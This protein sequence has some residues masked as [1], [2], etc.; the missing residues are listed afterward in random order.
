MR[1]RPAPH[2]LG[3]GKL[4]E[5]ERARHYVKFLVFAVGIPL[6]LHAAKW[7]AQAP[8][9]FASGIQIQQVIALPH[10]HLSGYLKAKLHA[11]FPN[12]TLQPTD[13]FG[14]FTNMS[15]RL[16]FCIGAILRLAPSPR[17]VNWSAPASL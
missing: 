9:P 6:K 7:L 4:E 5:S 1:N 8:S 13:E 10:R 15:T 17:S 11:K 2:G 12:H 3:T 16:C 14:L